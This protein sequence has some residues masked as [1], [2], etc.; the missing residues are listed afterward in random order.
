VNISGKFLLDVNLISQGG[1]KAFDPVAD[2]RVELDPAFDLNI[3]TEYLF[4]EKVS[5]F[6]QF[7]NLTSNKYPVFFNYPVRG[8][9]VL[10]GFTW[11]F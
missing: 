1:M 7:N 11:S 3:R 5:I 9:Q 2:A 8:F 6:A 10:G 4:S